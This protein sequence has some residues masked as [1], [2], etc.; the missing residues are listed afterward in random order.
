MLLCHAC[1][2]STLD[3]GR[4]YRRMRPLAKALG[5]VPSRMENVAESGWPDV[6][7]RGDGNL[8]IYSELK[9]AKGPRGL[10]TVRPEQIA[11]AEK[12]H[13]LGGKIWL[14]AWWERND[15]QIWCVPAH[16]IRHAATHGCMDQP[17]YAMRHL[18]SLIL[19]WTGSYVNLQ[20]EDPAPIPKRSGL[21]FTPKRCIISGAALSRLQ[22]HG[23]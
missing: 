18:G 17:C 14:L 11:W 3:E 23:I 6:I 13:D 4:L 16:Q 15:N 1:L 5:L 7:L 21:A 9:I 22:E 10:I 20:Q 12:H 8:H 2:M 19:S